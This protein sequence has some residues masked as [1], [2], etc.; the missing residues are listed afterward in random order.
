[1]LEV[2]RAQASGAPLRA[3]RRARRSRSS[4]AVVR[5]R[6]HRATSTA[7]SRRASARGSSPRRGAS[8]ASS[9]SSTPR[10]GRDAASRASWQERILN[11]GSRWRVFKR[12]FTAEQLADELGGGEIL[13]AGRWFVVVARAVSAGAGSY[14]SLA[15]LQ[16][17]NRALPRVRRGRLSARVAAGRSRAGRRPA[18]VPARPGA[19]RRRGRRAPPVARPR[20]PDAAALARARR[21]RVLRD[22]LLRLGHA[23]L[24]GGRRRAAATATPTAARAGALR[25]L[26][27]VGAPAPA[28]RA[29][30]HGRRARGAAAAR[31]H[32]R[33]PSASASAT[34]STATRS[35]PAPAPL[36]RERLAQR[37]GR[38]APALGREPPDARP[39]RASSRTR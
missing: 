10:A 38:T 32:E 36:G 20:R 31:R 24:P 6:L 12:V 23:L 15:S 30:R 25:V 33:S 7:T 39:E 3:G 34:S 22:V 18:R 29:D 1:M 4:D 17:D 35:C 26:A 14:R 8:R 16:R 21:G 19:G 5:A 28:A 11:D 27:R 13:H 2:A 9:S 37:P